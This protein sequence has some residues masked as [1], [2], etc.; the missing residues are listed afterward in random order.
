MLNLKEHLQTLTET[1]AP[2]GFEQ[3]IAQVIQ[4]AWQPY[5]DSLTLDR[6][7]S[8]IAVKKGSGKPPRCRLLLAS[9][10]DEIGL[11][12]REIITN[13]NGYGFLR[14]INVGG[15]DTRHLYGQL[16]TVHGRKK[17][18]QD[19]TGIVGAL[20]SHLQP[21]NQQGKAFDYDTLVVDTGLS[22]RQLQEWVSV[23]DFIS[24]RQSFRSL[25]GKRVTN[26][27]MDNRASVAAVTVCL[28]Y[29]SQRQ[30]SWDVVAVA[31][32][33]EETGL[34]GA[35][36]AAF[37][38]QPNLAIAID[39]TF[40]KSAGS[41]DE[42]TYPL[43]DGPTISF[44]PN[45]HPAIYQALQEAAEALELKAAPEPHARSSGTD[46]MGMQIARAGIPT[47]V[48]GI[49]LRYMHTLVETADLR[50]IERTGRLLGEF[51][52]RLDDQF[53]DQIQKQMMAEPA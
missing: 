31:T 43:G 32:V 49:P 5:A 41:N 38:Q 10:S 42:L 28:D 7:G 48:V 13:R 22:Y 46:A 24:F 25:L 50:D 12:V 45:V 44:G 16:V 30:H 23:G 34:V 21:S 15:I 1:A 33:Q 53:L 19:L 52:A 37:H 2:S 14:V 51:V 9:H 29:L 47:G 4:N 36:T 26:K 3:Q 11:M 27:A 39:V 6:L 35:F 40:G 8:L 17:G 18:V 20:P